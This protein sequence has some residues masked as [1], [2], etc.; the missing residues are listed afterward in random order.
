MPRCLSSPFAKATILDSAPASDVGC[1]SERQL[2]LQWTAYAQTQP[3]TALLLIL[4]LQSIVPRLHPRHQNMLCLLS[5]DL[6]LYT[7]QWF[8]M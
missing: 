6:Q 2:Y 7:V 5:A 4:Q 3:V 8:L 1:F